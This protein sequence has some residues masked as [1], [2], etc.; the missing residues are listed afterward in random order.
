MAAEFP[1]AA[2]RF[3]ILSPPAAD[4]PPRAGLFVDRDGVLVAEVEYL[5]R[6]ADLC[7]LDGAASIIAAANAA[8]VAAVEVSNQSGIARGMYDWPAY[9][10]VEAELDRRL[11]NGGAALDARVAC[12][13]HPDFTPGWSASDAHWRK[14][15]PGMLTLAADRL[16]LDL[17][18]SWMVG[19]LASDVAAARTAGLAGCVHVATGHG[20]EHRAA[21]LDLQSPG[22]A[23]LAARDLTEAR[24][25][26]AARGLFAGRAPR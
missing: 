23:V 17:G 19:D 25:L 9:D 2:V 20:A 5:H 3:E 13:A 21:A 16:R 24:D 6:I 15:G 22:F 14:P 12:G 8:A 11:A 26:L 1:A 18:R 4:L 10:A 7:L